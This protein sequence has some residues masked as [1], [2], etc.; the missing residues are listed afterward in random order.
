M[1]LMGH[2]R[3]PGKNEREKDNYKMNIM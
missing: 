2:K 1:C 3:E